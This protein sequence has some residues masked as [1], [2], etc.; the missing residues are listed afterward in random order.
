MPHR[1]TARPVGQCVNVANSVSFMLRDDTDRR[2][3]ACLVADGRAS[4]AEIA[5]VV[6]LSAPATKRRVDRLVADGTI[7]G[8]TALVDPAAS[9]ATLEG[10]VELHCR[11]RTSPEAIS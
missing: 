2:I 8:F 1:P 5:D 11:G 6:G 10:F 9:G 4:F 3:L 7:T